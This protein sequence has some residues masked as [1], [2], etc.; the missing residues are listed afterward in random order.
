[1]VFIATVRQHTAPQLIQYAAV[2]LH[3]P[4]SRVLLE[5]LNGSVLIK[6]WNSKVHYRMHKCPQQIPTLSHINPIHAPTSHFLKIHLNNP[7]I[8]A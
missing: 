2:K 5:K 3:T 7:P 4:G 1:M 8:Y 6:K